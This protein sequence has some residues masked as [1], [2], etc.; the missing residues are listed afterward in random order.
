MKNEPVII[1]GLPTEDTYNDF[2]DEMDMINIAFLNV[3]LQGDK[4]GNPHTFP[5]PTYSITKDFN[6]DCPVTDKLFELTSKFGLPYFM[7]YIGSGLDPSSTRS[8]CCR[9][10]LRLEDVVE[11]SKGGLWNSG[12]GTG[13]LS[14]VT[15]NMPQLGFLAHRDSI[16]K[17]IYEPFS[18]DEMVKA[19]YKRLDVLLDAARQ[20]NEWKR[21]KINDGFEMGLMPFSK[22]YMKN[23]DSFFSTIGVVGMNE[24]CLNMFGKPIYECAEFVESVLEYMHEYVRS[25]TRSCGYPWNLEETPSEGCSS[26]LAIKD[27]AQYPGIITQGS[28][29]GVF[30]TNSSHIYVGDEV[31]LGESLRIQERFKKHFN[32]GTLFHIFCGENAPTRDGVKDLIKNICTNTSIPYI[33]LT[34]AYS[35]CRNCGISDDLSGTCP[36]CAGE[37]IVW[38][39]VTG[40]YRPVS[41]WGKGKQTEFKDRKRFDTTETLK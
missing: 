10:N 40:F 38:D 31:G 20:H 22:S 30:Y 21:I 33:A 39:R 6:W 12:V 13:S 35:V 28:G 15:I 26:S 3:M 32:G 19:F 4:D 18:H 14:V 8:M 16:P 37:T 5:I 9:L 29:S 24:C 11:A 41:S 36:N 27:V 17:I 25:L 2:Q 7:N 1:G 23:F 34:R